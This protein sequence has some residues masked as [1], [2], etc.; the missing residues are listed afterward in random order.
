[1]SFLDKILGKKEDSEPKY[2]G[3]TESP[4]FAVFIL[5]VLAK[6]HSPIIIKFTGDDH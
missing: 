4:E 5:K 2:N 3:D 6:R 1:M